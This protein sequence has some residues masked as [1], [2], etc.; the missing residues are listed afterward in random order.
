[1]LRQSNRYFRL[2]LAMWAL[3]VAGASSTIAHDADMTLPSE[4]LVVQSK[5]GA[6]KF[7]VEVAS[8]DDQRARGL[9]FRERMAL[10]AG[11]LFVFEAAGERYFWMKNTP[12][13]LD[14][15]FIGEDGRV[16]RIAEGTTPFS[17]QIIPSEAPALSVLEL[18]A[19]T[20]RRLG[21]AP[22]DRVV[23]PSL[24]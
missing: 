11:M 5:R 20:S 7:T 6:H 9:M 14:I 15:L 24:K 10:N 3:I 18:L 23:A 8:T 22:G 16:K 13:S 21:I 2:I 4:E 1:M 19:G 12:L 17:E